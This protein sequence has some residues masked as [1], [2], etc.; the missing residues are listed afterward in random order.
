MSLYFQ[1]WSAQENPNQLEI[2]GTSET[3][4]ILKDGSTVYDLSSCSYHL[5]F[6]L[7]NKNLETAIIDQVTSLPVAGPKTVFP[8][9][10]QVTK[11]LLSKLGLEGKLF[12]T[13]SGAESVENALKIARNY[14]GKTDILA[15]KVSY[16]GATIGALS[17]TG[18]WRSDGH[19]T[20]SQNTHYIPE[21]YEKDA[22]ERT[23]EIINAVGADNIS[24]FILETIT[25][26]NGVYIPTQEW[27]DGIQCLCKKYDI[28]LIL[29]EVVCGFSRTGKDFGFQNF[30]LSPDIICLAKAISGGFFPFG[31][32][33]FNSE[34][35]KH[36]DK[37]VLSAGLTNYAH[38]IGLKLCDEVLNLI[39]DQS[40]QDN[41]D[42]VEK[43][44]SDF[45]ENV[46]SFPNIKEVRHIGALMAIEVIEQHFSWKVFKENGLYINVTGQNII[47]CPIMTTD[48]KKLED[49]LNKVKNLLNKA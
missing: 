20:L 38:P 24:A 49:A 2:T 42:Q 26:G 13:T 40:F 48:L 34:I 11:R 10:D 6:G 3:D 14:S 45:K 12:Y 41:L 47:I 37:N 15:R 33:Y 32:V 16:H 28:L 7:R 31:A 17:A 44:L 1:T 8:L 18:D 27:W 39:E 22:L 25:G 4:Y 29:D 46:Q 5:G 36:Y 43:L 30:K 23:E 35:S 9:K 21:P 19:L